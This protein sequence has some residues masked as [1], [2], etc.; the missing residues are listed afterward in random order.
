MQHAR[1]RLSTCL[2]CFAIPD[3]VGGNKVSPTHFFLDMVCRAMELKEKVPLGV[4]SVKV[5]VVMLQ[6]M[7][8]EFTDIPKTGICPM[9]FAIPHVLDRYEIKLPSK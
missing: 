7:A 8:L 4:D 6:C 2:M 9:C 1:K 5:R 3:I